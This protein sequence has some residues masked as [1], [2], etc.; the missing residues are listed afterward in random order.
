MDLSSSYFEIIPTDVEKKGLT[1]GRIYVSIA[2]LVQMKAKEFDAIIETRP[3][4]VTA[5]PYASRE[6]IQRINQMKKEEKFK[7]LIETCADYCVDNLD[8]SQEESSPQ[9]IALILRRYHGPHLFCLQFPLTPLL[10]SLPSS[11]D[12][13]QGLVVMNIPKP[14]A[15]VPVDLLDKSLR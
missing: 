7:M 1:F 14:P 10:P 5:K 4:S 11:S 9:H 13:S 15:L 12:E 6:E 3:R 2:T 8:I